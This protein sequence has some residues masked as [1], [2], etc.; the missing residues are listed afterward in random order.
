MSQ[1]SPIET[2][3]TDSIH[4]SPNYGIHIS[5]LVT[6]LNLDAPPFTP[7]E[8]LAPTVDAS[9]VSPGLIP[10]EIW[11]DNVTDYESSDQE[12]DIIFPNLSSPRISPVPQCANYCLSVGHDPV[13]SP[14]TV[15]IPILDQNMVVIQMTTLWMMIQMTLNLKR[16]RTGNRRQDGAGV[17]G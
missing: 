1:A 9:G 4:S 11:M 17:V 16:A 15:T 10:T 6:D 3:R 7:G 14:I 5:P 13:T 2:L 8:L 12:L